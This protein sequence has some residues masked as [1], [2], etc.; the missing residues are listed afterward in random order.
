MQVDL[1]NGRKTVDAVVCSRNLLGGGT[2]H[3]N[4]IIVL[5]VYLNQVQTN[6]STFVNFL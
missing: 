6:K 5:L 4:P 2:T 3:A 1:Y